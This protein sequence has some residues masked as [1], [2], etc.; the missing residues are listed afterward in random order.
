LEV[1]IDFDTSFFSLHVSGGQ[2]KMLNIRNPTRTVHRQVCFEATLFVVDRGANQQPLAY[3][4]NGAY[5]HAQLN[6]SSDFA[7]SLRELLHK[8]G[9]KCLQYTLASMED[10]DPFPNPQSYM[11]ELN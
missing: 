8:F 6:I 2:V 5:L 4:L 9:I 1:T 7:G 10:G 3:L 11:G